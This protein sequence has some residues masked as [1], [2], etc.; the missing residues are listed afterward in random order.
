MDDVKPTDSSI[1]LKSIRIYGYSDLLEKDDAKHSLSLQRAIE[2]K[3]YLIGKGINASLFT[4]VEGKGKKMIS[5]NDE[6]NEQANQVLV[7]IEYDAIAQEEEPI[8]IKSTRKKN[9]NDQ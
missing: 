3:K 5:Q 6:P 7:V 8:I 1:I 4:S 9:N 2:V